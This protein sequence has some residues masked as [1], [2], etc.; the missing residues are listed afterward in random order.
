MPRDSAVSTGR[1]LGYLAASTKA[2]DGDFDTHLKSL[3]TDVKALMDHANFLS[4]NLT[5]LLDAS[6]GLISLEQNDVMRLF[7]IIAVVLM[8]PTLVAGVY[9]MNFRHMPELDWANGYPFALG[10]ILISAIVP[11]LIARRSGWL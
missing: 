3:H 4:D 11:Y 5:F 1:L 2:R 7:S 8:P 6:L 10:L 9:G